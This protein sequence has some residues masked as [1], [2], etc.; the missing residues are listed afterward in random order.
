MAAKV[1]GIE[2]ESYNVGYGP[3]LVSFNDTSNVEYNF[4]LLPLGGY[5]AFPTN[6]IT[7][8][9]GDATD[10]EDENPNL[11]QNRAP[12]QRA[13]VISGGVAANILLSF[14]ISCYVAA[15]SGL[16][17][18]TYGNGIVVNSRVTDAPG[19]IAGVK[20]NDVITKINNYEIEMIYM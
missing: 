16:M 2:I 20:I 7:D 8:E 1:Q 13:I 9:N 11:L 10:L 15:S 14:L 6:V 5:V 17:H 19:M 4:R 18:P 12:W 3:K